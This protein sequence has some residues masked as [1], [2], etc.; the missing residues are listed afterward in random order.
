MNINHNI[1]VIIRAAGDC[2]TFTNCNRS[3]HNG[4]LSYF[5]ERSNNAKCQPSPSEG[6]TIRSQKNSNWYYKN[7][8]KP[9]F[10]PKTLHLFNDIARSAST[11]AYY[12]YNH[13]LSFCNTHSS[14]R[15]IFFCCLIIATIHFS[16][17]PH[18]DSNDVLSHSEMSSMVK[19]L[20][21]E[22]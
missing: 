9:L 14:A 12:Q 18:C 22:R 2:G 15:D 19:K 5:R 21:K 6:P 4:F 13:L 10:W 11:I 1:S 3:H 8:I 17:A 7:T 16:C 20:K